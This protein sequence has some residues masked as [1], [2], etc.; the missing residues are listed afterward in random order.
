[1]SVLPTESNIS[2]LGT[3]L[4]GRTTSGAGKSSRLDAASVRSL[5]L[6]YSTAQVDSLL[7]AYQPLDADLTAIAALTTTSFGR[8]LLTQADAAA[9]RTTI[10]A[11]TSSF[12][13]AFSSLTGKPTTIS[14]YGITNA[15]TKSEVDNLV[16]GLLDF[17]GNQDCSTNPNY[18]S[19][20]KGDSYYVSVA[21]KIGGAS[22]VSV[23][24]GDLIVCSADNAGGTQAS[25]GSSWFVLEKNLNG[26]LVSSN[27]L[28]DL[29]NA[30]TARSNLGLGS[31]AT[32]SGTFSGTSSGTNT[33]D[34]T[35]TLTGDVTGSG[36]GSFV[37]TIGASKVTNAMLAGSI[38]ASKL[39]GTDIATV[40]TVT[41]GTWN[42][43]AVGA[44][45][46]GTGLN[47]SAST[48][49][50]SL[51]TG[52]WSIVTA[53]TL[54]AALNAMVGDSGSGG[55]KGLVPAPSAGDAAASKYLKAD[56]T[57]ATVSGGGGSPGGSSGQF[58]YNNAG[59]FGGTAAVAYATTGTH[60]VVTA[61]G[62]TVVPGCFKGAA[63]QSAN[64]TEWQNSG[65]TVLASM[66]ASGNLT[67]KNVVASGAGIILDGV[68]GDVIFRRAGTLAMTVGNGVIYCNSNVVGFAAYMVSGGIGSGTP[69]SIIV[70]GNYARGGSDTNVSGGN[71]ILRGGAGTGNAAASK[72]QLAVPVPT[73]SGTTAQTHRTVVEVDGSTTAGD[74]SLL[75]WDVSAGSLKRVS[76]GA[77]DSG[78]TGFKLLRVPN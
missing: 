71:G 52:T 64:L 60:V 39:V 41:T 7:A 45:Y 43:T 44:Q 68:G 72:V 49:Y 22:G 62:A 26:A 42:A 28:S 32:Q 53:T 20:L 31:L 37:A 1:M 65:G 59:A 38:A 11:G 73:T 48:G 15:Y 61:Q 3:G 54:T 35:I 25:V 50:P 21:G 34:Q 2:M 27:N 46:G 19:G 10:G 40:G 56:G 4:L 6:V 14:G 55:T 18:P 67:C 24:V 29:A 9:V 74:T 51:S 66:D 57:W 8:S 69:G 5:C 63:S 78:G 76:I 23:D 36:T 13:G 12:D 17:K 30:A 33:G 16:A 58:Q 77:S 70:Q 75:L 47:T